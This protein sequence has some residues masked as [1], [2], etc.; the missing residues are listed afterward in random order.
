[1]EESKITS[2]I[3]EIIAGKYRTIFK[4]NS[5]SFGSVYLCNNTMTNKKFAIKLTKVPNK[6][7]SHFFE[8]KTYLEV[9][10]GVGI[11]KIHWYGIE[12]GYCIMV[13]DLLGPSLEDLLY[14]C[15]NKFS[16]KTVLMLADQMISRIEY[17]HSKDFIH[18]DIK[19]DNFLIGLG[20]KASTVY[21]VDFGL[22]KRYRDSY[23]KK[24]IPYSESPD[25]IGTPHFMT[26]MAHYGVELSRRDDL[27]SLGYVLLY[28]LK[29][30][31]PW[32]NIKANTKTQR[33]IK[34]LR[35]KDDTPLEE[36]CSG[37]PKEFVEYLNYF[38][39]LLFEATP[40]YAYLKGIF[41]KLFIAQGFQM[42]YVFDWSHMELRSW[43]WDRSVNKRLM[44]DEKNKDDI[45]PW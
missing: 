28:L 23:T 43:M 1:M 2:R 16:L 39:T 41:N 26:T 32:Q 29:G 13:L 24:H 7:I 37:A 33:D 3:P 45:C 36:I 15:N 21:I 27:E 6:H 30:S 14:M 34:I 25:S 40:D 38:T 4:I 10:R 44:E 18:R 9:Q 11:P 35:M 5:G 17:L 42:D 20:D 22:A 12:N 19:P 8:S 31:L